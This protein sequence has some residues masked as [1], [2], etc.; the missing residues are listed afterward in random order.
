V[1]RQLAR[2]TAMR[3]DDA[4]YYRRRALQEQ[5]AAAR[6]NCQA[7]RDRHDKLATMY[8]FRSAML[9]QRPESWADVLK[10]ELESEPA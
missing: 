4:S 10:R 5:V 2:G 8:R 3:E 6:A 7:A 1:I 9:T